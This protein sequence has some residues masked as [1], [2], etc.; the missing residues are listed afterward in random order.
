MVRGAVASTVLGRGLAC[1]L[2]LAFSPVSCADGDAIE[3]TSSAGATQASSGDACTDTDCDG[4]CVDLGTDPMNCGACGRSCVVPNAAAICVAGECAPGAC[5]EGFADCDAD[6][7]SGCELAIDCAEGS[8][9]TTACG[10]A[11]TLACADPCAPSCAAPAES[12]NAIDDDCDAA[13]DQGALAGCRVGV[14][15]AYNGASGHLYT[16]DLAEATAWG[17]ESA[18]FF[19]LYSAA[20]ADLRPFFRCNAG[21]AVFYTDSNDCELTGAPV[22]TVG[23]IAPT[24]AAGVSPTCGSVPLYRI[25]HAVNGWHFYTTSLAERDGAITA[26]GWTDEGLAGFIWV[27]P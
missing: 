17:L 20:A 24:P 10:S 16:T 9:C 21:S 19:Y 12:C 3:A 18:N 27:G 23:F 7:G 4:S 25:S 11:G 13:C 26:G 22:L 5:D 8:G 1:L 15:R 6:A 2:A 14:H